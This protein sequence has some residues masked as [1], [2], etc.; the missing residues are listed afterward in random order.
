MASIAAVEFT[1]TMTDAT[2]VRA[3]SC[4]PGGAVRTLAAPCIAVV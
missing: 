3:P 4:S 1:V 2:D